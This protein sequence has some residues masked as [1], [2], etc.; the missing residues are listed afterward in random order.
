LYKDGAE[1]MILSALHIPSA[2]AEAHAE[3]SMILSVHAA[4]YAERMILSA[5][6]EVHAESMILSAH[7]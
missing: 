3:K 1:S 4:L 2:H 7:T 6:N 5:H